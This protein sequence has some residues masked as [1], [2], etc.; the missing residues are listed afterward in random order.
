MDEALKLYIQNMAIDQ[1][2]NQLGD[3]RMDYLLEAFQ[4]LQT[5]AFALLEKSDEMDMTSVKMVTITTLCLLKKMADGKA[6][7]SLSQDDWK[8]IADSVSQYAII[9]DDQSY[10]VFVFTLYERYIR[11][12]VYLIQKIL[13][14]DTVDAINRL[15]DELNLNCEKL[16]RGE[17]SEVQ[18]TESCL[19]VSLEAMIKLIA[20][21]SFL[22]GKKE[23]GEF[24]QAL[25]SCSFEYGRLMLYKQEKDLVDQFI[26]SQNVMNKQL[27]KRY[28][29]FK[30]NLE[31]EAKNFE[32]LI[33]NAFAPDFRTA[34]LQ[35]I[36]LAKTAGVA[37]EEIL[38]STAD[39][40]DFFL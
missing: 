7:S 5:T 26:E 24:T 36:L 33:R 29:E 39:I 13:S 30:L 10:T 11:N 1:L 22:S 19:W 28:S 40:D 16:K 14:A 9:P 15:A 6:L 35:S 21:V 3:E 18:Y 27:E 34:F 38:S 20:S 8:D 25:A 17:I 2:R 31:K 37:E 23:I 4:K 12:S 32:I